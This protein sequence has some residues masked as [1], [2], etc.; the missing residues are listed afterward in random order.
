MSSDW[1]RV[2]PT[3]AESCPYA[4]QQFAEAE[5]LGEVVVRSCLEALDDVELFAPRGQHDDRQAVI[6]RAQSSADL[7][8]VDVGQAEVEH[9]EFRC[10]VEHGQ[11]GVPT[12]AHPG[13]VVTRLAEGTHQGPGDRAVIFDQEQRRHPL[14]LSLLD[15]RI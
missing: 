15:A 2:A 13:G 8:A 9:D 5:R 3:S 14:T 7:D 10:G 4:R 11:F 12:G 1:S 6:D